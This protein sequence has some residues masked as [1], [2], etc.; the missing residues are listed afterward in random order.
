MKVV[1][2]SIAGLNC[3]RIGRRPLWLTSVIGMLFSFVVVMGLSGAYAEHGQ[4]AVGLA[5][6]PFL[7]VF[8]GFYD[9]AWTPLANM[10][11]VEILPYNLRAKGQAIYNIAQGSANAVNQWVNPIILE[12]IAWKYYAVY[13][14]IL[15]FYVVIIYFYFPETKNLTME[16]IALVIDG[17]AAARVGRADETVRN[18]VVGETNSIKANDTAEYEQVERV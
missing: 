18:K 16:Q 15:A 7:F 3:D 9:I 12:A 10:Y 2:S 1:L 8:F 11:T 17:E 13:I 14:G 4:R 5:V 6:I